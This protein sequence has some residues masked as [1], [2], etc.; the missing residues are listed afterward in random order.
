MFHDDFKNPLGET[1]PMWVAEEDRDENFFYRWSNLD[2]RHPYRFE[3]KLRM[4]YELCSSEEFPRLKGMLGDLLANTE[5]EGAHICKNVGNGIKAYLLKTPIE[6]YRARQLEKE[7]R[8]QQHLLQ[9]EQTY[10]RDYNL[11]GEIKRDPR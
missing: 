7:Q 2:P 11:S 1:G 6:N 3:S 5:Q 4:G 9:Q 8:R 10:K